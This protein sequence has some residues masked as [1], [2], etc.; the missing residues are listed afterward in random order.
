MAKD[1]RAQDLPP[2]VPRPL[3]GRGDMAQDVP[4]PRWPESTGKPPLDMAQDVP[5]LSVKERVSDAGGTERK[6]WMNARYE[7]LICSE[8]EGR[9]VAAGGTRATRAG[10]RSQRRGLKTEPTHLVYL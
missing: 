2:V 3:I 1:E 10:V 5:D 8:G 6:W 7:L 9:S 4:R